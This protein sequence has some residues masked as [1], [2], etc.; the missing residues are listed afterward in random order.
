MKAAAGE[1]RGEVNFVASRVGRSTD[2][3]ECLGL[4][5]QLRCSRATALGYLILWEE[6]VLE[7]GTR[8]RVHGYSASHIAAKLDYDGRP[9]KLI[10][11]LRV[12]GVLKRHR[13]T[14]LHAYWSESITGSYAEERIR[15]REYERD[16]KRTQRANE[17]A[18]RTAEAAGVKNGVP[19][20]SQG[21]NG[22]SRGTNGTV[23]ATADIDQGSS[24][25]GIPPSPPLSG[26][27]L[28]SERWAWILDHHP[29][30]INP[31]PCVRYLDV[32]TTEDWELC[33]WVVEGFGQPGWLDSSRKKRTRR[34]NSHKFLASAAYLQFRKEWS[35]K[36]QD[37]SVASVVAELAD[38]ERQGIDSARRFVELQ[39]ADPTLSDAEKDRARRRWATLYPDHPIGMVVAEGAS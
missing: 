26:G 23:P 9:N 21:H 16:R 24:S 13:G 39:L 25:G 15:L 22:T 10:D 8:G 20:M 28:G 12:A 19:G 36:L 35:K 1:R 14:Y 5:K 29:T 27:G 11:A 34:L 2:P 32:M 38:A 30:P 17:A 7:A 6:F 37:Q 3:R 18:A 31:R 33:K 4:A